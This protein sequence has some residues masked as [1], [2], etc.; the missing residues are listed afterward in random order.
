[1]M[2][3]LVWGAPGLPD[4][5]GD[6]QEGGN[7]SSQKLRI[8]SLIMLVAGTLAVSGLF[9]PG[10]SATVGEVQVALV[11]Q[12][13]AA[14]VGDLI[15]ADE[16]DPSGA[17][18]G[19]LQVHVTHTVLVCV[20]PENPETCQEE[21]QDFQGANV[22]F[23]LLLDGVDVS[24]RLDVQ[25]RTTNADGRAMF[26]PSCDPV[27]PLCDNPLSIDTANNFLSERYEL[28]PVVN[29]TPFIDSTS[30]EFDI[31]GDGCHGNGCNINL[32]SNLETYTAQGDFGLGASVI[33]QD[34]VTCS[35]Q[36]VIFSG[37]TF[38][39]VTTGSEGDIVRLVTHITRA[40]M[41]AAANN[42]QKHVGWC[43]G[44]ES[45][46]PWTHNGAS[47]TRQVVGGKPFYVAMAP[48]CP[49][50]RTATLFAPCIV[51]QMG[52][53]DGGS[54]IQGYVLGGDPPRRT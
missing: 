19:Y 11:N 49:N 34:V 51:S 38:F 12:P 50:K 30:N 8:T 16:F 33:S 22:T 24:A 1:M 4:T 10:A 6:H 31:W 23:N 45:S 15:T 54:F 26:D 5:Y 29:E 32:R 20:D 36:K 39:H 28:V 14:G 41:K 25:A 18:N 44:L 21:I 47:F 35:D 52:D 48:K 3:V 2:R 13:A 46:T 53:N 17:V 42:G 27:T 9:A 40:D 37:K 43:I 7:M